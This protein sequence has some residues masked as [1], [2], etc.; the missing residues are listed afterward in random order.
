MP[1]YLY[2]TRTGLALRSGDAFFGVPEG[3]F[4]ALLNRP[5]LAR[6]LA[7]LTRAH[8]V[9]APSPDAWLAPI[10]TQEIWA[11]G[12]TYERSREGR[13]EEAKESGA[14]DFYSRVYD[15]PRPELFFKSAGWRAVGPNAQIRIRRD[16]RWNVPEPELVLAINRDRQIVGY[17]LG[18]DVSSRDIEGENPLY[19]P[20]AKVYDGS[21][22]LGPAIYLSDEPLDPGIEIRLAVERAGQTAFSGS[23]PLNRI[24]RPFAE[25]VD[26]LFRELTFPAGA[27]LLTGT[28]IVPP[29]DFTLRPGDVV[30]IAAGPIGELVNQVA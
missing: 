30:R 10:G 8:P 27:F 2:R 25:L 22:A 12:V 29:H 9:P 16:A 15:A 13:R 19:L 14:A 5:D 24:R 7:G 21:C 17:T 6:H 28:G 11:A 18:N 3:D 20:Q 4:D 1:L 26:Y 23:V